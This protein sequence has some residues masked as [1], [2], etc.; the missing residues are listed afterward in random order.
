MYKKKSNVRKTAMVFLLSA[1]LV[2]TT[3]ISVAAEGGTSCG[4]T[5]TTSRHFAWAN[6]RSS[7]GAYVE[8]STWVEICVPTDGHDE[9]GIR[10]DLPGSSIR[11]GNI[12]IWN[13]G[14]DN[15]VLS[16]YIARD[17]N[18]RATVDVSCAI[19]RDAAR[20]NGD[21][22]YAFYMRVR[23]PVKDDTLSS[24]D[25]GSF[26]SYYEG[27]S[28]FVRSKISTKTAEFQWY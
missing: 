19:D 15:C 9:I 14:L 16:E 5:M 23:V 8:G 28:G 12:Q 3:L 1:I 11:S 2:A 6:Q 10:F 18:G 22:I 7:S 25:T 17:A 21:G 4:L 24:S 20:N 13:M 26:M 27:Q